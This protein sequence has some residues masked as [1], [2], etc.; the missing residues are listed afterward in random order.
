MIQ[1]KRREPMDLKPLSW[2]PRRMVLKPPPT[3]VSSVFWRY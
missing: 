3:L 2:R 1:I